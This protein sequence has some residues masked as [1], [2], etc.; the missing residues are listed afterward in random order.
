M[1]RLLVKV[2]SLRLLGFAL[3]SLLQL[4][5]FRFDARNIIGLLS[6]I[7]ACYYSVLRVMY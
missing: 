7:R 6:G 3:Q 5:L 1:L 2:T 4:F